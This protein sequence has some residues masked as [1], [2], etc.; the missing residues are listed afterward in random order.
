[1]AQVLLVPSKVVNAVTN[2]ASAAH[3]E[4]HI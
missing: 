3:K 1:M 4:S 2:A